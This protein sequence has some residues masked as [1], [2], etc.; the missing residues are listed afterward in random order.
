MRGRI[1]LADAERFLDEEEL[2]DLKMLKEEIELLKEGFD[3]PPEDRRRWEELLNK[4]ARGKQSESEFKKYQREIEKDVS[5][6]QE[7]RK[8]HYE[9]T[10]ENDEEAVDF[11][12]SELQTGPLLRGLDTKGWFPQIA[13]EIK[14]VAKKM[15]EEWAPP[16]SEKLKHPEVFRHES[17]AW[18]FPIPRID[19]KKMEGVPALV[20]K[21]RPY[22]VITVRIW[23]KKTKKTFRGWTWTFPPSDSP[24]ATFTQL[25]TPSLLEMNSKK[26]AITPWTLLRGLMSGEFRPEGCEIVEKSEETLVY[27]CEG[28]KERISLPSKFVDFLQSLRKEDKAPQEALHDHGLIDDLTVEILEKYPQPSPNEA[29]KIG[30]K[31]LKYLKTITE[32]ENRYFSYKE[33]GE[34]LGLERSGAL[35]A[36][37]R[38][39]REGLVEK[40]RHESGEGVKVSLTEKARATLEKYS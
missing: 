9:K 23:K 1:T 15:A 26:E 12:S 39:K 14:G 10:V 16:L 18:S 13:E 32:Y 17:K 7:L 30:K 31:D 4:V 22:A 8:K 20:W 37:K 5:A 11:I 6:L 24:V 3:L 38:L 25:L 35:K 28:Y 21:F 34:R 19:F 33:W 27:K 29:S 2:K 40:E 36:I